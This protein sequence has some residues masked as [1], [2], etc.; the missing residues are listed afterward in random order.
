MGEV[1]ASARDANLATRAYYPG[2]KIC[3]SRDFNVFST[4]ESFS[5]TSVARS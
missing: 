3:H 1:Y 4:S 5:R 2:G